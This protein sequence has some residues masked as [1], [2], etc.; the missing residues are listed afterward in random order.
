MKETGISA[1]YAD[2]AWDEY[3]QAEIFPR[4]AEANPESIQTLIDISALLRHI[5]KRAETRAKSY[6]NSVYI[7]QARTEL[8]QR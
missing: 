4:N 2:R 6:I 7:E 1:Q 5:P 8:S 3:T